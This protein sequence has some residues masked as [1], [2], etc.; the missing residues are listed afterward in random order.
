MQKV[1]YSQKQVAAGSTPMEVVPIQVVPVVVKKAGLNE[2]DVKITESGKF[3]IGHRDSAFSSKRSRNEYVRLLMNGFSTLPEFKD[4][5][6]QQ[7]F[8]PLNGYANFQTLLNMV[9]VPSDHVGFYKND[10]RKLHLTSQ[11]LSSPAEEMD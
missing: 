10:Q 4:V 9:Q 11:F 5:S 8:D 7:L 6:F 3:K 1:I 2:W